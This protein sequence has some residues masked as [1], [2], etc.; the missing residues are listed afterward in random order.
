MLETPNVTPNH[1]GAQD[2]HGKD[3]AKVARLTDAIANGAIDNNT[4][5]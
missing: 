2:G 4:R 5:K 3:E 1:T